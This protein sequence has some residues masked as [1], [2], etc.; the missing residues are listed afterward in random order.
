MTQLMAY[1][2]AVGSNK[3]KAKTGAIGFIGSST[4]STAHFFGRDKG[5]GTMPHALV[6][7]AGSTLR[8][9][10]LFH[11]TVPNMPLTVLV[12]YFGQE[13]TPTLWKSRVV[14][15]IWRR[16]ESWLSG[17]TRMADVSLKG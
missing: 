8:A 10:E 15:L 7:Y 6:G 5:M 1:G 16:K 4:D 3:A 13:I 14:F 11:E 17:S 2:A 12:D 9:A